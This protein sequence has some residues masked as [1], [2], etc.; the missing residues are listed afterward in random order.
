[1]R[2][3]RGNMLHQLI[4]KPIKLKLTDIRDQ[5]SYRMLGIN[6]AQVRCL[7][8][9]NTQLTLRLIYMRG[10]MQ[11]LRYHIWRMNDHFYVPVTEMQSQL[12]G[13][14]LSVLKNFLAFKLSQN[15]I[16]L[17]LLHI[18][19]KLLFEKTGHQFFSKKRTGFCISF[20]GWLLWFSFQAASDRVSL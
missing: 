4:H 3:R 13:K 6:E 20:R 5:Q 16:M 7:R 1:M 18:N 9:M 2:R 19:L 8:Q 11:R 12:S 15:K 14:S 17:E 10:K